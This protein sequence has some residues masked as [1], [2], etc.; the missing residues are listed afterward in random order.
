VYEVEARSYLLHV[1]VISY[2]IKAWS[3][4]RAAER[5]HQGAGELGDGNSAARF[6]IAARLLLQYAK[7]VRQILLP[8]VLG[9]LLS[10][11]AFA[12]QTHPARV[13]NFAHLFSV[14]LQS[15]QLS[16]IGC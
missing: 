15:S 2:Q 10:S 9:M 11:S 16:V 5:A 12:Q 6:N 8:I 1:I 3:V 14:S 7:E 4:E 13:I